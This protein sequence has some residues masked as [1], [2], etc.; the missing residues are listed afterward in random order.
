MNP[1]NRSK[2]KPK[3]LVGIDYGMSR[4]GIALSDER[5]MIAS[6]LQTLKAGKKAELTAN[7]VL[8]LLSHIEESRSCEIEAVIVGLPLMMS[9]RTGFL[10]DEVQYFVHLLKQDGP[11]PVITWDERLTTVQAE[12]SLRESSMTRKKRSQVVDI[13][14]AAI[15]LQSYLDLQCLRKERMS[16]D[17]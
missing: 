2:P 14:S 17:E 8:A 9:G 3:R 4:I 15:I 7:K 12:R 16:S 13:V 5:Q 11:F 1:L 10:A 6:P